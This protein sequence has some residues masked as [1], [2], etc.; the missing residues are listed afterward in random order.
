MEPHYYSDKNS[1]IDF[2]LQFGADI[3]PIEAKDGEDK[4][5]PSFKKYVADNSPVNAIRFSK[6]GYRKDG[7]F[8]NI[9]L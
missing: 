4:S 1:E 6:R 5:A 7:N 2:I 8:V 3:V 9:P